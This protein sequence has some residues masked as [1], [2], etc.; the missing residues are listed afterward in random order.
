MT[1]ATLFDTDKYKVVIAGTVMGIPV[2]GEDGKYGDGLGYAVINKQTSI[3]EHT[4]TMLPAAIYQAMHF[5]DTLTAQ[6]APVEALETMSV[7]DAVAN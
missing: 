2:I 1:T 5:S 7:V 6:L 3:A 4:T